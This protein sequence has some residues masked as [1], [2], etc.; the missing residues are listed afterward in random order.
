MSKVL[1]A[2]LNKCLGLNTELEENVE[3]T[4]WRGGTRVWLLL[5]K[6]IFQLSICKKDFS[7]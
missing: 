4:P 6:N 5:R 1:K 2:K 7:K 3:L